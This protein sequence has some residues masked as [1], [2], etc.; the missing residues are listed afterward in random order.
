MAEWY[1]KMMSG[2]LATVTPLSHE[3][4]TPFKIGTVFE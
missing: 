2:S 1:N 4:L 3:A